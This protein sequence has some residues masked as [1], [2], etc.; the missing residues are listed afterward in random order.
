MAGSAAGA[1]EWRDSGYSAPDE[2]GVK[3]CVEVAVV[4]AHFALTGVGGPA[5]MT[6]VPGLPPETS[7]GPSRTAAAPAPPP[8]EPPSHTEVPQQEPEPREEPVPPWYASHGAFGDGGVS[9]VADVAAKSVPAGKPA[10]RVDQW[11][12]AVTVGVKQGTAAKVRAGIIALLQN[13]DPRRWERLLVHGHLIVEDGVRVKL[14]F[15]AEELDYAPPGA[16]AEPG[17]QVGFSKYGDTT[18][19][20]GESHHRRTARSVQAEAVLFIH[21]A[22]MGAVTH[23]SPSVKIGMESG[24]SSGFSISEEKQSGTRVIANETNGFTARIRVGATV[25]RQPKDALVLPGTAQL[26]FP[27]VYASAAEVP[28]AQGEP[29]TGGHPTV[30]VVDTSVLQGLD[31]AVNAANAKALLDALATALEKELGL[32]AAAVDAIRQEIAEEYLNEKTLKDRSQWWLTHSWVTGL[33]SEKLSRWSSFSGHL[34][35]GAEPRTVRYV[36]TTDKELLLRNDIA[37]TVMFRHGGEHENSASITPGIAIGVE[38]GQHLATPSFELP[39]FSSVRGHG[40][41]VS[42]AGQVKNA[43]MRKDYLVRYRTEFEMTVRLFSD[44]GE[45]EVT[46][47][48][49]SEL[50]IGREHAKEFERRA[51]GG[52]L[53]GSG[54]VDPAEL[55]RPAPAPEEETEPEAPVASAAEPRPRDEAGFLRWL[56]SRFGGKTPP[57][58]FPKNG[59]GGVGDLLRLADRGPI[60][61]AVPPAQYRG[62]MPGGLRV[63][64]GG[65][66]L[67]L[68]PNVTW[69]LMGNEES[70]VVSHP[71][72][73]G[74]AP[75]RYVL[76]DDARV[77][78]ALF[79]GEPQPSGVREPSAYVPNP[80]AAPV[81]TVAGPR[82]GDLEL[83]TALHAAGLDAIADFVADGGVPQVQLA[84]ALR[85][86]LEGDTTEDVA[87]L[88]SA[89]DMMQARP[90]VHVIAADGRPLTAGD[91][92]EGGS[93]PVVPPERRFVIDGNGA[94][95]GPLRPWHHVVHPREPKALAARKGFG[96]GIV[97]EMPGLEVVYKEAWK[98]LWRQIRMVV[99][100]SSLERQ[101]Q[102]R[103]FSMK[104]GVPGARG[105]APTLIDTGFSYEVQIGDYIFSVLLDADLR[106][107]R[108]EP[109]AESGVTMDSQ[110]KGAMAVDVEEKRGTGFGTSFKI[111]LRFKLAPGGS[112]DVNPLD[113]KIGRSKEHKVVGSRGVKE[114]R[115]DRTVGDVTGFEYLTAYRLAVMTRRASGKVVSAEV[116]EISGPG[117]WTAVRV[118]N[119]YLPDKPSVPADEDAAR[120]IEAKKLADQ[121]ELLTIGQV[122]V[123]HGRLDDEGLREWAGRPGEGPGVELDLNKEGLSGIQ[124]GLVGLG[125]LSTQLAAMVAEHNGVSW[126]GAK[127]DPF[128]QVLAEIVPSGRNYGVAQRIARG[129]TQTF[130]EAN[131]RTVIRK[132]GV[133]IP[134]PP[135]AD[136][137]QQYV[138]IR[139]RTF[140]A[141]HE[142]TVKG[143]SQE[144]YTEVDLRLGESSDTTHTLAASGGLNAVIRPGAAP[145][146][147]GGQ[148]TSQKTTSQ[149]LFGGGAGGARSWGRH[150][151]DMGGALDLNLGTYS[152]DS[153]LVG[154]DPVFTI[155]HRRWRRRTRTPARPKTG[156]VLRKKNR[157]TAPPLSYTMTRHVKI[158]G[159]A[160]ILFPHVRAADHGLSVRDDLPIDHT[161]GEPGGRGYL[162]PDVAMAASYIEN[163][164][165][166]AVLDTIERMLGP[167]ADPDLLS[168][169]GTAFNEE[170]LRAQYGIARRRG[171]LQIFNVPA[172][173]WRDHGVWDH[174]KMFQRTGGTVH[175][176]IRVTAQE[177]SITYRRPRP[178]V[179][180][181]TGGQAFVQK[182]QAKSRGR[183]GWV[184]GVLHGRWATAP[185]GLRPAAGV[186]ARYQS[187]SKLKTGK[188]L[189]TRDIRRATAKDASQEFTHNG[190]FRIEV[191]HSYSPNEV[192]RRAGQVLSAAPALAEVLSL[193]ESRR[194]WQRLFPPGRPAAAVEEVPARAAVL[195]PT[196]LTTTQAPSP[197]VRPTRTAAPVISRRTPAPAPSALATSL[198]EHAQ[199][200]SLPE[201]ETL[202]SWAPIAAMP[203]RRVDRRAAAQD[204][205]P[206]AK[207]FWPV[208]QD[209]L[210]L[211]LALDE[212]ASRA[213]IASLLLG[214]YHFPLANGDH[215]TVQLVPTRGRW[216]TRG[217]YTAL[218]FPEHAAEPELEREGESG[219][220]VDAEFDTGHAV[221]KPLREGV[222]HPLLDGGG[223]YGN[224]RQTT[225]VAKNTA[226]DYVESNRQRDGD[227]DYY[228]FDAE[229]HITG[230]HQHSVVVPIENGLTVILPTTVLWRLVTGDTPLPLERPPLGDDRLPAEW[231]K[232]GTLPPGAT[233]PIVEAAGGA[234]ALRTTGML[235][236]WTRADHLTTATTTAQ[237]LAA[238]IGVPVELLVRDAD[239]TIHRHL[240][241]RDEPQAETTLGDSSVPAESVR[242]S[243]VGEGEL[244]PESEQM[245]PGSWPRRIRHDKGEAIAYLIAGKELPV[246]RAGAPG[247]DYAAHPQDSFDAD[248]AVT[249][250]EF[251]VVVQNEWWTVWGQGAEDPELRVLVAESGALGG[252]RGQY[253]AG[254]PKAGRVSDRA[255]RLYAE[256]PAWNW[257]LPGQSAPVASSRPE[258]NVGWVPAE[259][260]GAPVSVPSPYPVVDRPVV[261]SSV[262]AARPELLAAGLPHALKWRADEAP[263]YKFTDK[264]PAEVLRYGVL[265][266]G[267]RLGH[268]I[269]HVYNNPA[270]TGYV[271]TSRNRNYL[272]DSALNDPGSAQ[273]LFNKYQWRVDVFLPG[274]I[275]VNA[276]LDIA[277]P[278]PDQEEV[279]FPGGIHVKFIRGVQP[280]QN[281]SLAG[282]Y[283]PNPAFDPS[284]TAADVSP[285]G[286]DTT[287][288][289]SGETVTQADHPGEAEPSRAAVRS[290]APTG[291]VSVDEA[292]G[293]LS[294]RQATELAQRDLGVVHV[295]AIGDELVHALSAVATAEISVIGGGI[296]AGPAELRAHFTAAL[297]ADLRRD[298]RE[299]R[300]WPVIGEQLGVPSD[301]RHSLILLVTEPDGTTRADDAMLVAAAV[302]LGLRI[303]VLMPA[304]ALVEFGPDSGRPVVLVR[305]LAPGRYTGVWAATVSVVDSVP[306][307]PP[308]SPTPATPAA[309]RGQVTAIPPTGAQSTA[310][311]ADDHGSPMANLGIDPFTG[312]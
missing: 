129:G 100:L 59:V 90:G 306:P 153:E 122:K 148:M 239:G 134:L 92:G 30:R 38:L 194:M 141:R 226:A 70:A 88:R 217:G 283:I 66:R 160:E 270:D 288:E 15:A 109:K 257:Y 149:I 262:T 175:T 99:H 248:Y 193:G 230:P 78:G 117:Y 97:R 166:E 42:A 185:F 2:N 159:A 227:F 94:V 12:S 87:P 91:A 105:A 25:N 13:D 130:L 170:A 102:A 53:T 54:L 11:I 140:N 309:G 49:L 6:D 161:A 62:L 235:R 4:P 98:A 112:L 61:I 308:E 176:G 233:A 107:L 246:L 299:Q 240:V 258:T 284:I 157:R 311:Q 119:A 214:E 186:A 255:G 86:R 260:A 305:L 291:D 69:V 251:P 310:S 52:V 200:L 155:E 57:A 232:N 261:P 280:L 195:V 274:G 172:E 267:G 39:K 275:D 22:A 231:A 184:S 220:T 72:G 116:R 259:D 213:D 75:W 180:V 292:N 26:A 3:A 108:G 115:R 125:E 178:D 285:G 256:G 16:P 222:E 202:A 312:G 103:V 147:G 254:P 307:L 18:W 27:T 23:V 143:V 79:M 301:Q 43:T 74:D 83:N 152:G 188:T 29:G 208:T 14:T 133:V 51:L 144:Q 73:S 64:D 44:K 190:T 281:G 47:P 136:G 269:E 24:F 203:W 237:A 286:Y 294:G 7:P 41:T 89:V 63:A 211:D 124:V 183:T 8:G 198:A 127:A 209:G 224:E 296:P 20:E 114:Y 111:G 216:L 228:V 210:T 158:D 36:T 101:H 295:P 229:Y 77:V 293:G 71:E 150:N 31:Y 113:V 191:F 168:A 9:D 278:F 163:V 238:E 120:A 145:A 177:N 276:T 303:T 82:G 151:T 225:R 171:V 169:V 201:S 35:I 192:I 28:A 95:H 300:L 56:Q 65:A 146:V 297:T 242:P 123:R 287:V 264:P 244:D 68:H 221:G 126:A 5:E 19:S 106:A 247:R 21:Q 128:Q 179:R 139:M 173:F 268:L 104:F 245:P 10:A 206:I 289:R 271:S 218:N 272:R 263:L 253:D 215:L 234:E 236:L 32:P 187:G 137:W 243:T 164:D 80:A 138:R 162:H 204:Q 265:P 277:S 118:S 156:N 1:F 55:T 58:A 189:V 207:E 212:H 85:R 197:D 50:G 154:A 249:V 132:R 241:T 298:L 199:A 48:V 142:Q 282:G 96:R 290:T 37:D 302:V 252:L 67:L 84:N 174:M 196:H 33:L 165:A 219:W 250:A 131:A 110:R 76:D 279:A 273:L 181:T 205:A 182:G 93:L 60:E 304:G 81:A 45:V 40:Y 167:G 223:A 17:Q 121:D 135:T 266:K 34:E 46:R